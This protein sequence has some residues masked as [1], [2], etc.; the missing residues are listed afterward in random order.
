ME[1]PSSDEII[2]EFEKRKCVGGDSNNTK[3]VHSAEFNVVAHC[4]EK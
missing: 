3:K 2:R 4:T 1:I